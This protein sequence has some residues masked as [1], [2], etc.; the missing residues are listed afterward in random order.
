MSLFLNQNGFV[1]GLMH[2]CFWWWDWSGPLQCPDWERRLAERER[3]HPTLAWSVWIVSDQ[4]SCFSELFCWCGVLVCLIH[5]LP[6]QASLW[7]HMASLCI[8]KQGCAC[9]RGIRSSKVM[10][11]CHSR[12]A[13]SPPNFNATGRQ[14]KINAAHFTHCIHYYFLFLHY[15]AFQDQ[16]WDM[17]TSEAHAP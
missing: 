17:S 1:F 11:C 8:L 4:L 14:R 7:V 2:W 5:S 9:G 6:H 15:M 12:R 16:S 13:C 10:I 3:A